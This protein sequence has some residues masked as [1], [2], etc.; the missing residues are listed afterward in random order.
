MKKEFDLRHFYGICPALYTASGIAIPYMP[1][2]F[3]EF[4]KHLPYR[5]L[6][7]THAWDMEDT[8]IRIKVLEDCIE[9]T[10]P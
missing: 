2:E 3:P 5:G 7:Y 1:K 8:A 4:I 9:K 6:P 10:K